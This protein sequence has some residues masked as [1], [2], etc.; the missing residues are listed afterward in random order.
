MG[1]FQAIMTFRFN[2]YFHAEHFFSGRAIHDKVKMRVGIKTQGGGEVTL[3]RT[4][5]DGESFN[6]KSQSQ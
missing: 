3:R 1:F 4:G 2:Q 6:R 5:E